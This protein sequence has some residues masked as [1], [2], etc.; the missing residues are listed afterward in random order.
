MVLA[1]DPTEE[2]VALGTECVDPIRGVAPPRNNRQFTQIPPPTDPDWLIDKC[3]VPVKVP[4]HRLQTPGQMT[5]HEIFGQGRDR[6]P[7]PH[8]HP[9]TNPRLDTKKKTRP[10][11]SLCLS[12]CHQG[13]WGII[14]LYFDNFHLKLVSLR[15]W[16]IFIF[17]ASSRKWIKDRQLDGEIEMRKTRLRLKNYVHF[18]DHISRSRCEC[19]FWFILISFSLWL[20]LSRWLKLFIYEL[21]K[22]FRSLRPGQV[23]AP[24]TESQSGAEI[25]ALGSLV[26]GLWSLVFDPPH[27]H[28][29]SLVLLGSSVENRKLVKKWWRGSSWNEDIGEDIR[30]SSGPNWQ[31]CWSTVPHDSSSSVSKSEKSLWERDTD[32]D[33]DSE[34]GRIGRELASQQIDLCS[35]LG[36]EF[37]PGRNRT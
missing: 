24:K 31:L 28:K 23:S 35:W 7:N 10:Y 20:S 9:T 32:W 2:A 13:I 3:S 4:K 12:I 27:P 18:Y 36:Q 26:C 34:M 29:Y 5:Q 6:L 25:L 19:W 14:F 22:H 8:P 21:M 16:K 11:L 15:Q 33:R 37:V 30:I 1:P 17:L